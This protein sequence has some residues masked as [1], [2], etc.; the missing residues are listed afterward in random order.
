MSRGFRWIMLTMGVSFAFAGTWNVE[1]SYLQHLWAVWNR[2]GQTGTTARDML[3]YVEFALN[4][5]YTVDSTLSLH[6]A[7]RAWGFQRAQYA[8]ATENLE[9]YAVLRLYQLFVKLHPFASL[10]LEVG[11]LP[12]NLGMGLTL[13]DNGG[14]GMPGLRMRYGRFTLFDLRPY[15]VLGGEGP[16]QDVDLL[17]GQISVMEGV[18]LY[19]L[20]REAPGAFPTTWVGVALS[21]PW[22]DAELGWKT[23]R[24]P[25]TGAGM[26]WLHSPQGGVYAGWFPGDD[27][28]TP[29]DE[30]WHD[31]TGDGSRVAD[32]FTRGWIGYGEVMTFGLSDPRLRPGG[33]F[34]PS[35][36][37]NLY[38]GDLTNFRVI[39]AYRQK[40][41][42]PVLTLR[43][44]GV[45]AWLDQ[46]PPGAPRALGSEVDLHGIWEH[47]GGAQVGLSLGALLPGAWMKHLQRNALPL[48]LRLWTWIPLSFTPA[49]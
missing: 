15:S 34:G 41:L 35:D 36:P 9:A 32:G 28:S 38:W 10:T 6:T 25:S 45:A 39:G 18:Q 4:G 47:E 3:G 21:R 43:M 33:T 1:G 2:D 14:Y 19:T 27:P 16:G 48:T 5:T 37:Y 20:H 13:T 7:A 49:P 8:P 40:Q 17:G 24:G 44:D 12:A 11:K 29:E 23:T 46:V 42:S 26:V 22:V 31:A 30:G